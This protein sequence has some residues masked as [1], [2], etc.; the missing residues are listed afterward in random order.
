MTDNLTPCQQLGYQEGDL[1]I[2]TEKCFW[3]KGSVVILECDDRTNEP[4]F[5]ASHGTKYTNSNMFGSGAY[6]DLVY[7]S[8][9]SDYFEDIFNVSETENTLFSLA[10]GFSIE[11]AKNKTEQAIELKNIWKNIKEF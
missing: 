10:F 1:F 6:D 7:V 11:E 9:I 5:G 3:Y 4:L 8:K 2:I